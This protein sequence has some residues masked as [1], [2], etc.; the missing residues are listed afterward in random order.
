[1]CQARAR[2][3]MGRQCGS[4]ANLALRLCKPS[5]SPTGLAWLG[6]P[7]KHL[8]PLVVV[9]SGHWNFTIPFVIVV[10]SQYSSGGSAVGPHRYHTRH[11][12]RP[13]GNYLDLTDTGT[14]ASTGTDGPVLRATRL[15]ES[16]KLLPDRWPLHVTS[17][18]GDKRHMKLELPQA[19]ISHSVTMTCELTMQSVVGPSTRVQGEIMIPPKTACR[20]SAPT[21]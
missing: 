3:Y 16:D 10:I 9:S 15:K 12:S 19:M 4:A 11:E 18:N 14:G 6:N 8:Q 7:R 21:T 13:F 5:F 17:G 1:M 2:S 20:Q